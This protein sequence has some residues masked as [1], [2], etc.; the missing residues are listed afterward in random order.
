MENE[1]AIIKRLLEW[2]EYMSTD[3]WAPQIKLS[4]VRGKIQ[5]I[6]SGNK[7]WEESDYEKPTITLKDYMIKQYGADFVA[8]L[9]GGKT[10][11]V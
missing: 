11:A 9:L 6:I 1:Q 4:Y 3:S 8:S 7:E 5:E 10:N 2:Q